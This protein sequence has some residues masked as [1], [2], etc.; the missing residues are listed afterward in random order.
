MRTWGWERQSERAR[1]KAGGTVT[2]LEEAVSARDGDGALGRRL[3][4][5]AHHEIMKRKGGRD[6]ERREES[7][8]KDYNSYMVALAQHKA[9][10]RTHKED[11]AAR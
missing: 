11:L 9:S 5:K 1:S 3:G 8:P 7:G 4:G 2:R 10:T 6:G